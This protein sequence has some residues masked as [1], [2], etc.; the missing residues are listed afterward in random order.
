MSAAIVS[1]ALQALNFSGQQYSE[2][3]RND[4]ESS[5]F[6]RLFDE[7]DGA[8]QDAATHARA[9]G[10]V[11]D[12]QPD[13]GTAAP[14]LANAQAVASRSDAIDS[15]AL[16]NSAADAQAFADSLGFSLDG[17]TTGTGLFSEMRASDSAVDGA[18][19]SE[20]PVV[21]DLASAL[22]SAASEDRVPA[23]LVVVAGIRNGLMRVAVRAARIQAWQLPSLLSKIRTELSWQGLAL[24]ALTVN[25][26]PVYRATN[27]GTS[28]PPINT[29]QDA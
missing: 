21:P 28:G 19:G 29:Q 8:G 13:A 9:P 15:G 27:S 5:A 17:P 16:T 18:I 7:N 11:A 14:P 22:A 1:P 24:G 26:Q 3:Q 10:A 20:L 6:A 23:E 25:G 4:W 2:H 12:A